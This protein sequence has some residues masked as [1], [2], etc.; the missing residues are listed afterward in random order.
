MLRRAG[1]DGFE[2]LAFFCL[3]DREIEQR[4]H[5]VRV[6]GAARGMLEF[7]I[8]LGNAQADPL[9]LR[10]RECEQKL[11]AQSGLLLRSLTTMNSV[12]GSFPEETNYDDYRDVSGLKVPFVIHLLSPEGTRT[13][14]WDHVEVNTPVED[15]RFA[16]PEPP[17]PPPPPR[18]AN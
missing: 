16:K 18:P 7:G 13:Y 8:D 17:T 14:R 1:G 5:V 11:D 15:V 6:E 9:L 4:L 12:L 2:G 3:L 10:G